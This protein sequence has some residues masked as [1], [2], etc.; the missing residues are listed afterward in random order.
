MGLGDYHSIGREFFGH[1]RDLCGLQPSDRVLD[2]GCGTGR[3]AVPLLGFLE[4][5][6]SY[7]GFDVHAKAIRWC[8]ANLAGESASFRFHHLDAVN[9]AYNPRGRLAPDE[10]RFPAGDGA[11]TFAFAISVFTHM[12]PAEVEHYLAELTR[13]LAPGGRALVSWFLVTGEDGASRTGPNALQS[14]DYRGD[15]FVGH[16]ARYPER[17][18]G[19]EA[20]A[21]R[22]MARDAGLE[23]AEPILF[24]S[25]ATGEW[26]AEGCASFQDLMV[27]RR[28]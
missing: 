24:G 3:M 4:P 20:A 14:F 8:R 13:V 5:P 16:D 7:D 6:G 25:W 18:I 11:V 26:A 27:L 22:A 10:V 21:A 9:A 28:P 23:V 2:V 19:Y 15:G 17:A 1:F 12:R